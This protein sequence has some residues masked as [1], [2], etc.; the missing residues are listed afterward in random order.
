LVGRIVAAGFTAGKRPIA[1]RHILD[2]EMA[3]RKKSSKEALDP[4]RRIRK[5]VPPP[6]RVIPD[7][8]RRIREEQA[9]REAEQER[10]R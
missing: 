7:R 5:R 6:E 8:R 9:E 10:G 4:Y 2:G 1:H 3:P